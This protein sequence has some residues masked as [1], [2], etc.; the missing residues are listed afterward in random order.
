M[1]GCSERTRA[2]RCTAFARFAAVLAGARVRGYDTAI[3]C[4]RDLMLHQRKTVYRNRQRFLN[5]I[6]IKGANNLNARSVAFQG[7][8]HDGDCDSTFSFPSALLGSIH[9]SL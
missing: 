9:L 5:G 4:E 8:M 1:V 7:R 2:D 6:L 3:V